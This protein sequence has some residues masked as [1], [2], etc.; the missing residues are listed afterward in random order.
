MC[1]ADIER[2]KQRRARRAGGHACEQVR[3]RAQQRPALHRDRRG[4]IHRQ[5]HRDC[6]PERSRQHA[7]HVAVTGGGTGVRRVEDVTEGEA[8]AAGE[9]R[10]A[11]LAQRRAGGAVAAAPQRKLLHG[12]QHG[13]GRVVWA[14]AG[15]AAAA[16]AD[17]G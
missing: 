4:R 16:L 17:P 9:G 12:R 1:E 11:Q 7:Q 15:A 5:V 13:V 2:Q 8:A 6:A 10:A 3:R 14:V